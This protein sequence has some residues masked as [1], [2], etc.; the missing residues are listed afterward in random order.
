MDTFFFIPFGM[1]VRDHVADGASVLV[2]VL[3]MEMVW[4]NLH[5]TYPCSVHTYV[6]PRLK[7]FAVEF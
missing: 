3:V 4:L 7:N 2:I 6:S 1:A 5:C